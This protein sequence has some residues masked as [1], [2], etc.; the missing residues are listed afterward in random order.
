MVLKS[1]FEFLLSGT[2]LAYQQLLFCPTT[3]VHRHFKL[4]QPPEF[5]FWATFPKWPVRNHFFLGQTVF[6]AKSEKLQ[7]YQIRV[8]TF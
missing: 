1:H 6:G 5:D 3:F 2:L 4:L 8:L 7:K